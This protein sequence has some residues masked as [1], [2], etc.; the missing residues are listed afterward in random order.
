[1]VLAYYFILPHAL[2]P[3]FDLHRAEDARQQMEIGSAPFT[4]G[5]GL[6]L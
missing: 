3:R 1:M 4:Y 5:N 6:L 2:V